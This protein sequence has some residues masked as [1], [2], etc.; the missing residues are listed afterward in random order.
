MFA[1]NHLKSNVCCASGA[2]L[3]F[4]AV[5]GGSSPRFKITDK[6]VSAPVDSSRRSHLP[7]RLPELITKGRA[8]STRF[9]VVIVVLTLADHIWEGVHN[10]CRCNG[11][12]CCDMPIGGDVERVQIDRS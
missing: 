3:A 8:E 2:P 7:E 11:G 1:R 9:H 10:Q 4:S 5:A 6:P 12:C